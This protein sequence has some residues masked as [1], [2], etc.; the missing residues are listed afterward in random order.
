LNLARERFQMIAPRAGDGNTHDIGFLF[1]SSAVP[2]YAVT[3][4]EQ[5]AAAALKAADR[6]RS[7]VVTTR[8][9]AYLSSWGPLSDPRGRR[10]SA[11]DTMAN[12]SLLYWAADYADDG[13]FRL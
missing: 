11:I 9:G 4:E 7:R 13:S 10:S 2:L 5:Y 3:G 1:W 12:L 6:L 8:K